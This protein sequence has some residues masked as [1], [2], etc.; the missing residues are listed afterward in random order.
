MQA[1]PS[2]KHTL[3]GPSCLGLKFCTHSPWMT[4]QG[5][6]SVKLLRA[7]ALRWVGHGA[8]RGS[9]SCLHITCLSG[10][11]WLCGSLL[12]AVHDVPGP[13]TK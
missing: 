7:Q 13:R 4:L 9:G 12:K 10:V 3:T 8:H 1:G 11:L 5:W 2:M 6:A